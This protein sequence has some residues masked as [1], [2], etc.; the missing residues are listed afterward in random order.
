MPSH[1]LPTARNSFA[2]A[3][4]V[5]PPVKQKA[6]GY[7]FKAAGAQA[8]ATDDDFDFDQSAAPGGNRGTSQPRATEPPQPTNCSSHRSLDILLPYPSPGSVEEVAKKLEEL[9]AKAR[10]GVTATSTQVQL[11]EPSSSSPDADTSKD[12]SSVKGTASLITA[13]SKALQQVSHSPPRQLRLP[14]ES[15]STDSPLRHSG[16]HPRR[17]QQNSLTRSI[18]RRT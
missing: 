5:H 14:L 12:A 9:R 1:S 8:A 2:C 3:D 7:S 10:D 4:I 13:D 17:D 16:L 18:G 15:H 11:P 6:L